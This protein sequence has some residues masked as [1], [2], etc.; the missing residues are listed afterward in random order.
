MSDA[1]APIP[2]VRRYR[3]TA[4]LVGWVAGIFSALL[5]VGGGLIMVPAMALFLNIR[6]QRAVATSLAVIIPTALVGAWRYHQAVPLDLLV[7]LWLSLGGT[8]GGVVGAIIANLLGARQLRRLFGVFVI[9]VGVVM[10]TRVT[11]V[12]PSAAAPHGAGPLELIGVGVLVGV[13]SGL[14][15]VGGGLVMVPALVLMLGYGQHLAQG[16]SLAV[17][18]PVSLSGTVV[19]ARKGNILWDFAAWLAVGAL[20]GA[21]LMTGWVR[22]IPGDTLRMAFAVFMMVIGVSMVLSKP[23]PAPEAA[24]EAAPPA[25][26]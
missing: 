8:V 13:L 24:G 15:G 18:I 20:L 12:S 26:D 22:A 25:E 1:A 2:S 10:L 14:L 21:W 7:I 3:Y 19:H 9:G 11:D 5:G 6:A 23:R 17:I 4:L 16:T